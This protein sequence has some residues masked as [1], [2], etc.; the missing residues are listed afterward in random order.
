MYTNKLLKLF[1]REKGVP[2][3]TARRVF[4]L[5][6]E[7]RPPVQRVA[8]IILNKHLRTAEKV[9]SSSLWVGRGANNSSPL[10]RILLRNIHRQSLGPD[11]IF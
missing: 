7:E 5:W 3:T 4:R 9:W 6:L 1:P 10:K 2:V 8:A 11:Q